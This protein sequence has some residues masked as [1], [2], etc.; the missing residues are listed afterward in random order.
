[1]RRKLFST[2]L[3]SVLFM[4]GMLSGCGSQKAYS[5]NLAPIH[6]DTKD[7]E[8]QVV[9][10]S[11]RI[12]ITGWLENAYTQNLMA[13]LAEKYPEY[14]FEYKYIAKKSYESIIDSQLSSKL[15]ADIVMVNPLMTKRHAENGY[16]ADLNDHCD[17]FND[18]ARESFSYEDRMYAVP[19]TS[20]YQCPFYNKEIQSKIGRRMPNNFQEY[21]DYCDYLLDEKGIKPLSSGLKDSDTVADSALAFLASGYFTTKEGATFGERLAA[22]TTTFK[23]E[24]QPQLILWKEMVNHGILTKDMCIMDKEAAIEEFA[25]GESFMYVGG[26]EDYN[27][28]KEKNPDIKIGT[29]GFAGAVHGMPILIGGCNCGFAVNK[30]CT[31]REIAENIVA[32]LAKEEGQRVL[33]SDRLGS[34][35][36]L[37]G[38]SFSNPEEF[39]GIKAMVRAGRVFS[40]WNGWGKYGSQIYV[41]FGEE[42]QKVV[43]GERTL[44]VALQVIDNKISQIRKDN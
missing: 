6:I 9:D 40:P 42:L 20:E 32:E 34:Q 18:E 21:L 27:R 36:Y 35:T 28:I 22:G 11:T 12:T 8:V 44:D 26:V 3:C 37:R 14:T 16:I 13:Y 19:N 2:L 1:M 41:I 24:T 33:W 7:L 5:D 25:A 4:T 17:G 43:T 29:T 23:G 38:V 10:P 39:D 30:Y 31:N 15:A